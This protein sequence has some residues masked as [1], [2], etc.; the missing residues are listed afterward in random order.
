M[1]AAHNNVDVQ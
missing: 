1:I